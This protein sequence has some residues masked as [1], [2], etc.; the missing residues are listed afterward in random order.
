MAVLDWRASV[1][2][3]ATVFVA[4][5]MTAA[6][7]RA[8]LPDLDEMHGLSGAPNFG[9]PQARPQF[10]A[11]ERAPP[12]ALPGAQNSAGAA[13]PTRPPALLSPTDALFDAIDRGDLADARDAINRGADLNGHNVL[14]MTPLQLS[15]DLNRND[16]TFVLLANGAA[17][18]PAGATAATAGGTSKMAA[19]TSGPMARAP[20]RG[21][22]P[23]LARV[24]VAPPQTPRLFAGNGG[25]PVPSAGFLGFDAGH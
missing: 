20:R 14:G 18:P 12:A 13:P 1:Y 8:Q 25:T 5:M 11:P 22:R 24:A 21:P 4:I 16:I 23:H 2:G 10:G 17:A 6:P 3:A 15:I 19:T 9:G 7:C